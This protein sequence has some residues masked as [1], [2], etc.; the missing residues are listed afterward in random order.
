MDVLMAI[1]SV[2]H[3]ERKSSTYKIALV[4]ALVDYIIEHPGEH[5]RNGFH[6]IPLVEIARNVLYY[7]YPMTWFEEQ[8][9]QGIKQTSNVNL[10]MY[11]SIH[12]HMKAKQKESDLVYTA[13]EGLYHIREHIESGDPLSKHLI[14]L[15][16]DIRSTLL[17]QPLQYIKIKTS[18]EEENSFGRFEIKQ[19]QFVLFGLHNRE[20]TSVENQDYEQVRT[21][22]T[23]FSADNHLTW[24]ELVEQESCSIVMGHYTYVELVRS[25]LYIRD[26][27]LKRWIEYSVDAYQL[28][29]SA[30]LALIE[31]LSMRERAI[32]R[33]SGTIR[34]LRNVATEVFD[35]V[36]CIYCEQQVTSFALDH[37]IPWSKYP[38]NY[39][40]N[41]YPACT[42]CNSSKSDKVLLFNVELRKRIRR[43][44][45]EW[46]SYMKA[47]QLGERYGGRE[48]A[49]ISQK[50]LQEQREYLMDQLELI[51]RDIS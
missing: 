10:A 37:F 17:K 51:S 47:N 5:P 18:F 27:V 21:A 33:E 7:Y 25:R 42:S 12:K 38:T 45:E 6:Y 46:L 28:S 29:G 13:P 41:L 20:L 11:T 36:I 35:P 22:S 34:Y 2:L 26:A 19:R 30:T 3:D 15:I 48:F 39:F 44:L 43:Y 23:S 49:G 14:K 40:W 16:K 31:A 8:G 1:D 4:C 9:N 50:S 32:Q 24:S